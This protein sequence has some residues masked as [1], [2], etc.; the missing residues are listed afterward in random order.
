MTPCFM[1]NSHDSRFVTLDHYFP[2]TEKKD[3]EHCMN[4]GNWKSPHTC[5]LNLVNRESW[6]KACNRFV[7]RVEMKMRGMLT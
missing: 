5:T 4:C 1:N 6:R 7:D 2:K 3:T